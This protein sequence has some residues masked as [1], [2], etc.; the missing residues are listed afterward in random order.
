MKTFILAALALSV[1]TSA[2]AVPLDFPAKQP[3]VDSV[4][5]AELKLGCPMGV[6]D[7]EYLHDAMLDIRKLNRVQ[8]D[9][10][11]NGTSDWK[12]EWD[13]PRDSVE[14]YN[15]ALPDN[16]NAPL[17]GQVQ[18]ASELDGDTYDVI[19]TSTVP[20]IAIKWG[21][22]IVDG[23]CKG[24]EYGWMYRADTS[25]PLYPLGKG[26]SITYKTTCTNINSIKVVTN[27]GTAIYN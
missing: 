9:A 7:V 13:Y 17:G 15:E 11:A 24:P 10:Y 25:E 23:T 26:D 3:V 18:I 14:I 19:I 20:V 21:T 12:G 27:L 2:L 5:F 6:C 1:T 4:T 8:L 22:T 16:T